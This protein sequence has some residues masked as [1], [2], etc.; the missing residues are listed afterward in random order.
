MKTSTLIQLKTNYIQAAPQSSAKRQFLQYPIS[1][2]TV[3]YQT[4]AGEGG[5]TNAFSLFVS[6]KPY[7]S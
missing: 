3:D 6:V 5:T 1:T 7:V 2:A 4:W